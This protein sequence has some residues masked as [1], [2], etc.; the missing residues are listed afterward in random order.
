[1]SVA[2]SAIRHCS[3]SC[4]RLLIR[5]V[6]LLAQL[7]VAP[8]FA[9]ELRDWQGGFDSSLLA[10]QT[11]V[12]EHNVDGGGQVQAV[13]CRNDD[14]AVAVGENALRDAGVLGSEDVE[15]V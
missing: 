12:V 6:D 2:A 7:D 10:L 14:E 5:R 9:E 3:S 15:R 8:I 1:M 11:A 4:E 13:V